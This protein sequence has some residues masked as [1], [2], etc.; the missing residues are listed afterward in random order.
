[1]GGRKTPPRPCIWLPSPDNH[2]PNNQESTGWLPGRRTCTF[3]ILLTEQRLVDFLIEPHDDLATGANRGCAQIAGWTEHQPGQFVIPGLVLFQMDAHNFFALGGNQLAGG[4]G[5]FE[6]IVAFER[7]LSGIDLFNRFN[8][9][10]GKKLLR[11]STGRSAR[12]MI[13]PIQFRHGFFL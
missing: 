8:S 12:S 10:V 3:P 7:C 11:F 13:A 9:C 2:G 6:C 5:Q 1:M 4:A